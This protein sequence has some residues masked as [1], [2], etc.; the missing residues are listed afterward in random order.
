MSHPDDLL[1][2]DNAQIAVAGLYALEG[3]LAQNPLDSTAIRDLLEEPSGVYQRFYRLW[4]DM[5]G[6]SQSNDCDDGWLASQ[7]EAQLRH[8]TKWLEKVLDHA[9]AT[10]GPAPKLPSGDEAK[11]VLMENFDRWAGQQGLSRRIEGAARRF[12]ES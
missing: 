1:K 9:I 12:L 4:H 8:G 3:L 7:S 6:M 5:Q 10:A 11:S 2:S